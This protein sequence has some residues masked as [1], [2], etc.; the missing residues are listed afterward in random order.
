ML[1][2]AYK[3]HSEGYLLSVHIYVYAWS[4]YWSPAPSNCL[5]VQSVASNTNVRML[6]M[7]VSAWVHVCYVCR[8]AQ[9]GSCLLCSIGINKEKGQKEIVAFIQSSVH[10]WL[11]SLGNACTLEQREYNMKFT[12]LFCCVCLCCYCV[13]PLLCRV[14][15]SF[16][17]FMECIYDILWECLPYHSVVA[18]GIGCIL[19]P[20]LSVQW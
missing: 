2:L 14:L 20:L 7:S 8:H 13:Q 15:Y 12:A 4:M 5:L 11:S 17:Y 10:H 18:K 16:Q 9:Y 1:V 3:L 6:C 19:A